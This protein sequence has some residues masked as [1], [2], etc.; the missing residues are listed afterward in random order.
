MRPAMAKVLPLA[1][2][3]AAA[4]QAPVPGGPEP[5]EQAIGDVS[6]LSLSIR[7]VEPGL[8]QGAN[9]DQVFRYGD[10]Y[11]RV[12]GGL[13]AVFDNSV[14]ARDKSKGKLNAVVPPGTMYYIGPPPEPPAVELPP[15]SPD[16]VDGRVD[17]RLES[18]LPPGLT[19]GLLDA[20]AP[21]RE[22]PAPPPGPVADAQA[23]A[24]PP[25]EPGAIIANPEY[26]ALRIRMMMRRAAQEHRAAAAAANQAAVGRPSFSSSK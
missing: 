9:F 20:R 4:A 11:L 17:G 18:R 26:R 22:P 15:P 16:R 10:G 25:A 13:Y 21:Q 19:S 8:A 5:V 12:Q 14:Y 7:R 3:A 1:I 2:A 23:H 6:P 24:G